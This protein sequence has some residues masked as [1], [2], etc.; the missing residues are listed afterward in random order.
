MVYIRYKL[1]Y[2]SL[3]YFSL[4]CDQ[5]SMNVLKAVISAVNYAIILKDHTIVP[6]MMA[7]T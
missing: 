6:V 3:L 4:S 7:I 5:I 2:Q 1:V